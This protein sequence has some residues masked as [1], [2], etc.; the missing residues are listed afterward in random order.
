MAKTVDWIMHEGTFRTPEINGISP[1]ID[2]ETVNE[3]NLQ[4]CS[5]E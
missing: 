3:C 5:R 4:A 2:H 1:T